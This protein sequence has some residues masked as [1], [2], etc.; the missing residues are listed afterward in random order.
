VGDG[1]GAGTGVPG[2]STVGVWADHTDIRPTMLALAGLKDDYTP[3][4]RVLVEHLTTTPGHTADPNYQPLATCY[5]QLNA[6]VG[7]FGHAVLVGDT[8]ALKSGSPEGDSQYR[9]FSAR[10]SALGNQRDRLATRIK[11]DLFAAAFGAGLPKASNGEIS[12]CGSIIVQAESLAH[13]A[14]PGH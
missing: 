11:D 1:H 14:A 10:M 4:G 7:R 9:S 2:N 3:D 12:E 6:S 13:V 5:K 8:A